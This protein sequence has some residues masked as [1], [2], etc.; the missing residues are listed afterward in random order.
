MADQLIP[1]NLL[2]YK[3]LEVQ[4]YANTALFIFLG[5]FGCC[6]IL[7]G[8]FKIM[9]RIKHNIHVT[10]HKKIGNATLKEEDWV[11]KEYG[12]DGKYVFHYYYVG[13]RSP[14]ISDTYMKICKKFMFWDLFRLFPRSYL[15]FDS[16]FVDGK[17][18]P[19]GTNMML[20]EKGDWSEI[21]LTG[22]NYDE[23][24]FIVSEIDSY[25]V[26]K[27][28]QDR[29]LTLLPY[30]LLILI[31]ISQVVGNM[32]WGQHIENV[33]K[34]IIQYATKSTTSIIDKAAG[35]QIIPPGTP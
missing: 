17:L 11:M 29:F 8:I 34:E 33:V 24:N 7:F 22:I 15:S 35:V 25:I 26:K 4:G 28:R 5:L 20:D 6:L 27:Q 19:M 9:N 3:P 31:V 12:S 23:F 18:I 30:A 32:L 10:I 13:K 14:V 21:S 1:S 16:F 2:N